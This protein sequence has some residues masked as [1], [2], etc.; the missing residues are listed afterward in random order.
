VSARTRLAY[1]ACTLLVAAVGVV[2]TGLAGGP[3]RAAATGAALAWLVQAP[4]AWAL[5]SG[6][7]AGRKVTGRWAA[8]LAARLA[9]IGLAALAAPALG[10]GR[11]ATMMA[12]GAA[13]VA[14]LL[15]EAGWL[16]RSSSAPSG[17]AGRPGAGPGDDDPE[18]SSTHEV[19]HG[20]P[21]SVETDVR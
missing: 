7:R 20:S 4:A 8:G 18:R 2:A 12:Y 3:E 6:L 11:R 14:F 1:L 19:V 21:R 15:L 13:M 16:W 17:S 5:T 9:G 10:A